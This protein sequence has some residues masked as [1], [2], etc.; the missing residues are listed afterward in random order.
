MH[1]DMMIINIIVS[2]YILRIY[3]TPKKDAYFDIVCMML[4]RVVLSVGWI[5][6][7]ALCMSEWSHCMCATA[8]RQQGRYQR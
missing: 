7:F 3:V 5:I 8:D 6:F 4:C 2:V 1:M